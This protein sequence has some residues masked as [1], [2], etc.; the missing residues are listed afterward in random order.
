M[1]LFNTQHMIEEQ[2]AA[3]YAKFRTQ[4]FEIF[5]GI[6]NNTELDDR[7]PNGVREVFR[8][9]CFHPKDTLRKKASA[10]YRV[11]YTKKNFLSFAWLVSDILVSNRQRY[12][13]KLENRQFSYSPL[14]DRL[15]EHINIVAIP[16]ID[17]FKNF[18]E[19]VAEAQT[20]KTSNPHI[21]YHVAEICGR[22]KGVL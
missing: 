19:N 22:F 7:Y 18:Q 11:A 14:S 8:R 13:L 20:S 10:Y 17:E 5:G 9:V 16:T 1:A 12:L 6:E 4:F 21:N 3:T 15:S 2:V